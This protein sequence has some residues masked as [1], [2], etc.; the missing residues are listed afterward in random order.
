MELASAVCRGECHPASAASAAECFDRALD[1]LGGRI[2]ADSCRLLVLKRLDNGPGASR[3][4]V[5]S[6]LLECPGEVL[7]G[8]V[9]GGKRGRYRAQMLTHRGDRGGEGV[10]RGHTS[11]VG[12]RPERGFA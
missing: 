12:Y 7:S 6:E 3:A 8:L 11:S 9:C 2:E 4:P 5:C 10:D 1:L